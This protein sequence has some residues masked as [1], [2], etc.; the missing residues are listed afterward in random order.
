M[1]RLSRALAFALCAVMLFSTLTVV[2]DPGGKTILTLEEAKKIALENDTQ[3]KIQDSYV[4]EKKDNY[5]DAADRYTG[6]SKGSN[7]AEKSANRI[8]SLVNLDNAYNAIEIEEFNKQDLKRKSDYSVTIAYYG[9]MK[10]KYALD[11]ASRAMGLAK[12]DLEVGNIQLGIGMITKATLSQLENAY[13]ASQVTYNSAL[14]DYENSMLTLGNEIGKALDTN[15]YD[16]D[17]TIGIPITATLDLQKLKADNLK[18]NSSYFGL[19][20][21]FDAAK[22]RK[23]LVDQ[24][25]ED[26]RDSVHKVNSDIADKFDDME[27]DAHRDYN[28]AEYQYNEAIKALELNLKGQ[29]AGIASLQ[30]SIDTIRKSFENANTTFKNDKIKYDLGLISRITLEKSEAAFKDVQN[31]LQTAIVNLNSQYLSL[32]QYSSTTTK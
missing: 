11:N 23:A 10:A 8:N 21:A 1:R 9:V 2:G 18:N 24:E 3:Y 14:S 32:T 13:K 16:I 27:N 15:L 7:V 17:M 28:D 4:K 30:E 20:N 19:K 5:N 6:N 31:Q 25:Y 29:L 22:Y 12:K 26:Y